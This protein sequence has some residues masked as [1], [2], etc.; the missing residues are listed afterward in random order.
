MKLGIEL[1]I[2]DRIMYRAVGK[3]KEK[4]DFVRQAYSP[5]HTIFYW[6]EQINNYDKLIWPLR[7]KECTLIEALG[8]TTNSFYLADLLKKE[9]R[10]KIKISEEKKKPSKPKIY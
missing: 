4:S 1:L 2:K 7:K 9:N 8:G 6:E 10:Y 3:S 5:L